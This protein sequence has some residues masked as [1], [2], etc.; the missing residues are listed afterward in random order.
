MNVQ[1]FYIYIYTHT[2]IITDNLH[3]KTRQIKQRRRKKK[4]KNTHIKQTNKQKTDV[5]T[6][7]LS[8]SLAYFVSRISN[9]GVIQQ[10]PELPRTRLAGQ[11]LAELETKTLL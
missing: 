5:I 7:T 8:L 1:V 6:H 10:G 11:S 4:R 9:I 3:F 2:L